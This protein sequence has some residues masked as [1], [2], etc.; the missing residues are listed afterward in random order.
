MRPCLNYVQTKVPEAPFPPLPYSSFCWF[1]ALSNLLVCV[2]SSL[3]FHALF[4]LGLMKIPM[5]WTGVSAINKSIGPSGPTGPSGPSA[6]ASSRPANKRVGGTS[7]MGSVI[8]K[9]LRKGVSKNTIA[10]AGQVL[11]CRTPLRLYVEFP[12]LTKAI[13]SKSNATQMTGGDL[14]KIQKKSIP[15]PLGL[16]SYMDLFF[17]VDPHNCTAHT[18]LDL[19][20]KRGP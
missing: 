4:P 17:G 18:D 20:Q 3:H 13:I 9:Q 1:L 2:H 7:H 5:T 15:W 14:A 19:A 10:T 16:G 6:G 8:G 11:K 12:C